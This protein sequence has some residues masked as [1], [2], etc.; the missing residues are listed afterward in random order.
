MGSKQ[1]WTLV[2]SSWGLPSGRTARAQFSIA[3]SYYQ[4]C[5]PLR[6][7][8]QNREQRARTTLRRGKSSDTGP[9]GDPRRSLQ[10]TVSGA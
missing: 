7:S 8:E 5:E 2:L 1:R 9:Q 3:K 6:V 10:A 4:M